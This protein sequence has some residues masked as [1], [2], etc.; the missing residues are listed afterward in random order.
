M[1]DWHDYTVWQRISQTVKML[2]T[3]KAAALLGIILGLAS[4]TVPFLGITGIVLWF[5]GLRGRPRIRDNAAAGKAETIVLVGSEGGST[6]GFA[7]TLHAAL[8]EAGQSVHVGPM[9]SFNPARYGKAQRILI[10]AA[11]YGNGDAPAS[12]KGFLDRL[13]RLWQYWALA[14]AVSRIIAPLQRR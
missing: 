9:S 11:T 1:L 12:A 5:A 8:R 6:W 3:G 14:T 10:F 7:A 4:L 2:H 13:L